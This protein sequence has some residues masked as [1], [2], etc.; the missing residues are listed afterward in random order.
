MKFKVVLTDYIAG[1]A[2]FEEKVLAD[3]AEVTCCKQTDESGLMGNIEDAD[4]MIVFHIIRLTAATLHRIPKCRVI[5]RCGVGYDNVDLAAAGE[6]GIYVCNVPDYGV[7]EV[8]DHAMAL[9]LACARGF[10][11]ADRQLRK[12]LTPWDCQIAPELHRL[13]G[14]TFG[15]IGLG[16][17]GTAA[18]MRAKSFRMR[19]IAYDPYIRDG[20]D[21]ALD[22]TLVSVDQVMSA[23]DIISVHTPLTPETIKIVGAQQMAKM[24]P[25]AILINTARGRCVDTEALAEFLSKGKIGG[26]GLDVLPDEPPAINDPIV[27]LWQQEDPPI[28]LILTPH[29]AF[30]TQESREEMRNKS[31]MEVRR[32][33]LG[34]KPRNVVNGEFLA[35]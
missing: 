23:S 20:M 34:E 7:D 6:K 3:I 30:Y 13:A 29:S 4:A 31:A 5:V 21:K 10:P 14:A 35:K 19:V 33:L 15:I 8:A 18:A 17:I 25:H 28:N 12:S 27:K 9:M 16:R 1:P 2:T 24:K 26:A 11:S 22:V 32:V